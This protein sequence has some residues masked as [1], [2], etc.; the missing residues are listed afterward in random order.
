MLTYLH[1]KNIALI[2]ELEVDFYE[3]FNILTGETGAGKSIIIGSINAVLGNKVSKDFIRKDEEYALIELIFHVTSQDVFR[4]LRELEIYCDSELL[5]SRKISQNGRSVFKVNGQVVNAEVVRNMTSLLI[6]LHSQH[7][8]QSLLEKKNHI[9]L[10]DRYLGEQV[11]DIQGEIKSKYKKY[12]QLKTEVKEFT[13]DNETIKREMSFLEYEITEI[14]NA[15]L[16]PGEDDLLEQ[17]YK[18]LSNVQKIQSTLYTVRELVLGHDHV[19]G[20]AFLISKAIEQMSK[21]NG[22]DSSLSKLFEQLEQ[23]EFILVDFDHDTYDYIDN[24]IL[25]DE[26]LD[27][28]RKRIDLINGLKMKHSNHIEE[29]LSILDIKRDKLEKLL[30]HEESLLKIQQQMLTIENEINDLC[31]ILSTL[32]QKGSKML[33]KQVTDALKDL[34]LKNTE[35][36]IQCLQREGFGVDGWDD[37]EFMIITNIG[38]DMKPLTQIASGGE[39]SRVMLAIKSVLADCDEI[40]TLI[41]DEIDNGISGRTAQMVGEKMVKLSRSRQLICITHLP[42]IAAMA[43]N[44]YLIEKR[45]IK[46]KNITTMI[47]LKEVEIP[48]ELSRLI[49]GAK[50]TESIQNSAIEMKKL[51]NE[52][53]GKK[54]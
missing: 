39:L 42:Q 29:I 48:I 1:V 6:D 38:E 40:S 49:G 34:N 3:G 15:Q 53:K 18:K 52:V 24:L 43:D 5:I 23:L 51:A 50:I 47:K 28:I 21:I 44:H 13:L 22:L 46:D 45:S 32:R 9:R 54:N 7:E 11:E 26:S 27:Y 31:K 35:F 33:S 4:Q 25:D 41:F 37:V 20:A 30:H 36:Y 19:N 16:K 2:N 8:H 10:L 17:E 12:Q 14:E